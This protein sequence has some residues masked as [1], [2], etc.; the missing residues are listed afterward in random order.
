M[1]RRQT[2]CGAHRTESRAVKDFNAQSF[3]KRFG[4]LGDTAEAAFDR[5]Y[6]K[7]H[8]L[9]LNRP[10]F[11]MRG[12][13]TV[14]RYTPDRMIHSATVEVMAIGHDN[15]LKLKHEKLD[16]LREWAKIMPVDLF[17]YHKPKNVYWQAPI[18]QWSYRLSHHGTDSQFDDG[19]TYV[20]L[21]TDNFPSQPFEVPDGET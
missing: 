15:T 10:P 5:V 4:Y 20:A 1:G 12:M 6:P 19:K 8:K 3:D 7:H 16:A 2:D 11:S 18:K 17:V 14:M 13:D 9:G 21:H